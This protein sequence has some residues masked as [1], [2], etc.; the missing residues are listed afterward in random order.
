[1]AWMRASKGSRRGLAQEGFQLGEPLLDRVEV[2][3]VGRQVEQTGASAFDRR[4]DALDLVARQIVQDDDIARAQGGNEELLDPGAER[5]AVDR[6]VERARRDETVLP[7][8]ADEGG[9]LPNGPMEPARR[10]ARR[11]GIGRKAGSFWSMRRFRRQTPDCAGAIRPAAPAIA[12]ALPRCR[13]GPALRRA[14]TFF[15]RQPR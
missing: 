12:G 15:A 13:G 8:R 4:P 9:R 3:A 11:A 1:M 5:L 14:A 10:A 7:Q 6:P 2:G